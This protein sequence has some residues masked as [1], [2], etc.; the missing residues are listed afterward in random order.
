[1]QGVRFRLSPV[2]HFSTT[3]PDLEET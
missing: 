1:L 3:S 2:H